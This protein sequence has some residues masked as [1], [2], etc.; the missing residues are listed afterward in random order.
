MTLNQDD[1]QKEFKTTMKGIEVMKYLSLDAIDMFYL[2]KKDLLRPDYPENSIWF[3]F[4]PNP[5]FE[6]LEDIL[7]QW[8]YLKSVVEDFELKNKKSLEEK[9]QQ[10]ANPELV[11]KTDSE[12]ASNQKEKITSEENT[13]GEN[14][15]KIKDIKQC[16]DKA[17]EYVAVCIEKKE[18]PSIATAINIIRSPDFGKTHT[19]RQVRNW[20][21]DKRKRRIFPQESS[22]KGRRKNP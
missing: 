1:K 3:K 11:I 12:S 17:K 13:N 19:E 6:S 10:K 18:I 2:A 7:S 4:T 16:R 14:K 5:R 21:T 22:K 9:R 15:D 8:L 20:I